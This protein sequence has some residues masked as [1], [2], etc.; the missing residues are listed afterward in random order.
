MPTIEE[1]ADAV[2]AI[3]DRIETLWAANAWPIGKPMI[4]LFGWNAPAVSAADVSADIRRVAQRIHETDANELSEE[5][6]ASLAS[7]PAKANLIALTNM[8]SDPDAVFGSIMNFLIW[9]ER[10]LP[11][12]PARIDWEKIK[13]SS[14]LP[15]DLKRRL[16]GIATRLDQ[17]EPQTGDLKRQIAEIEAAH[18]AAEQLPTDMQEL[19]D[20]QLELKKLTDAIGKH[21]ND[22]ETATQKISAALKEIES[23]KEQ[24]VKLIAQ[25]EEAYRI[26]TSKGLAG[27][28]ER[29][30]G[31][32][33]K[34]AWVWVFGLAIALTCGFAIGIDRFASMKEILQVNTSPTIIWANAFMTI[35]GIGA[36]VWFAWLST[37]QIGQSFRLA[38]DYAF[39]ASVAK[40][41][42]GYRREAADLDPQFAQRL[43]GSALTRLEEA[44]IRLLDQQVHSSPM[45]ELLQ[46]AAFRDAIA[47]LP[48]FRD[49][50]LALLPGRTAGVAMAAAAAAVTAAS[51]ND[52]DEGPGPS[53]GKSA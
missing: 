6:S 25:C 45:Q 27:A 34:A 15:R 16:R 43:F 1:C 49:R 11:Q 10:L 30:A 53:V 9:I 31:R 28:F 3:A 12:M 13:D 42:E 29:R 22:A 35:V 4:E 26:T 33:N 50:I 2:D 44:P 40:A 5:A 48:G 21:G 23:K 7:L 52:E 20:Q 41:Y 14:E 24:A 32:L 37:K 18:A 19:A 47:T 36:P 38:E 51:A 46:N 39:K 8:N 17:M